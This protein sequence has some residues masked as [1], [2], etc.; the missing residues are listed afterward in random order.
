MQLPQGHN[1]CIS[2]DPKSQFKK[3]KRTTSHNTIKRE[4][5][6]RG[7]FLPMDPI[8]INICIHGPSFW[9]FYKGVI[10]FKISIFHSRI[11]RSI[12][13]M[14]IKNQNKETNLNP[15]KYKIRH[16]KSSKL[17]PRGYDVY[18]AIHTCD[19][20]NLKGLI[21]HQPL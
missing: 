11:F 8:T 19:S 10:N 2:K 14:W 15:N 16:S 6:P 20:C 5:D 17:K 13:R 21:L 12:F 3:K 9:A 1:C 18:W 7:N 4:R